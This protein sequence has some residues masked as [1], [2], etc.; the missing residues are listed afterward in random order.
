VASVGTSSDVSLV[1]NGKAYLGWKSGTI[2]RSIESIAGSFELEVSTRWA[3]TT[4]RFPIVEEDECELTILGQTVI[5]GYVDKRSI[6]YDKGTLTFKVSGRD[7]TGDLVDCSAVT[8]KLVYRKTPL[9]DFVRA[10]CE[11]LNIDVTLQP[12][13]IVSLPPREKLAVNPGDTAFSV[14]EKACKMVGMLPVSDGNGGLMLVRAGADRATTSLA[15][16]T[17]I[18]KGSAEYDFSK[19]YREYRVLAANAPKI[20]KKDDKASAKNAAKA[21]AIAR[22]TR[23]IATDEEVR[24]IDRVLVL[25]PE[26]GANKEY[27][28]ARAQWE[29]TTRA[30][31][32][33]TV[34]VTVHGWAMQDGKLWPVNALASIADDSLGVNGT[35]LITEVKYMLAGGN[36]RSTEI[37]LKRPDAFK[38]EPRIKPSGGVTAWKELAGGV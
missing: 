21:N 2:T 25:N 9:L 8:P 5:T 32:S 4:Q 30:A 37:T 35:M 17:N 26:D 19:R 1:V 3:G 23:G 14:I 36:G 31:K 12:G 28:E 22:R 16:G 15:K 38:P 27:A 34:T 11:P 18:L 29:A 7:K 20:G 24:R 6:S 33:E 10:V 13:F